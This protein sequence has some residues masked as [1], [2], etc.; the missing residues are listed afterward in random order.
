MPPPSLSMGHQVFVRFSLRWGLSMVRV[1]E[2]QQG[3]SLN[4][5]AAKVEPPAPPPR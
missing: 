4:M 3:H 5:A 2:S 1:A